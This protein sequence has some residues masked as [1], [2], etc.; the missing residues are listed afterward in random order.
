MN[1]TVISAGV[2]VSAAYAGESSSPREFW[3]MMLNK[4]DCIT[5][6]PLTRWCVDAVYDIDPDAQVPHLRARG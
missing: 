2:D 1:D 4:T 3:E 6:V 5:E